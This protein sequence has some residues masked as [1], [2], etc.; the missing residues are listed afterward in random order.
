MRPC[1]ALRAGLCARSEK[2]EIGTHRFF[3]SR[4]RDFA[5]LAAAS[6][7]VAC[8]G[9]GSSNSDSETGSFVDTTVE[10]LRY[11]GDTFSGTTDADGRYQFVPGDEVCFFIDFLA[12]G[13]LFADGLG[14]VTPMDIFDASSDEAVVQNMVRFLLALD[15]DGDPENGIDVSGISTAIDQV[16]LDF[17]QDMEDFETD[18]DMLDFLDLYGFDG[19]LVD[20]EVA[21]EHF[22]DSLDDSNYFEQDI[23]GRWLY[24]RS[25]NMRPQESSTFRIEMADIDPL[26]VDVDEDGGVAFV[27]SVGGDDCEHDG[28]FVEDDDD[29]IEG[30]ISCGGGM[31][32]A[33]RVELDSFRM[34]RLISGTDY[35]IGDLSEPPSWFLDSPILEGGAELAFDAEGIA[36]TGATVSANG[37]VSFELEVEFEGI[38]TC[39]FE[40]QMNS[41]KDFASGDVVCPSDDAAFDMQAQL[42]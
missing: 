29:L 3:H 26:G 6:V 18:E 21:A 15:A 10:G 33:L 12:L 19:E 42:D 8:S 7:A 32:A 37:A 40:G 38:E 25:S 9:G 16:A 39:L 2:L 20:E 41:A 1:Y 5:I 11:A 24:T 30:N 27:K 36:A 14:I 13:C 4:T 28:E 34:D 35:G 22:E 17:D 23:L 31:G